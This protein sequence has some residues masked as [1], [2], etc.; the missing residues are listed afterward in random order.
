MEPESG[1]QQN[2]AVFSM[3]LVVPLVLIKVNVVLWLWVSS[4]VPFVS[5]TSRPKL[6][7]F[8]L[9]C[10]GPDLYIQKIVCDK[11]LLYSPWHWKFCCYRLK[12]MWLFQCESLC[13]SPLCIKPLGLNC[14]IFKICTATCKKKNGVRR[15]IAVFSMG[16][17]VLLLL[18]KGNVF[19]WTV[20]LIFSPLCAFNK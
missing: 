18:I 8:C 14:V 20:G 12:E 6:C 2:I 5:C 19:F 17:V 16:L 9:F 7:E 15:N 10:T 11:T 3:G 4:F 1:V 13:L